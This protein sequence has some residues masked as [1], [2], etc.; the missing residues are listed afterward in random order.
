[1]GD[2][3]MGAIDGP[4]GGELVAERGGGAK[5]EVRLLD[6]DVVARGGQGGGELGSSVVV[7]ILAVGQHKDTHGGTLCGSRW[8]GQHGACRGATARSTFTGTMR[9]GRLV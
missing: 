4:A 3:D 8:E 6:Q 2:R 7:Q 1:V 5:V 9:R